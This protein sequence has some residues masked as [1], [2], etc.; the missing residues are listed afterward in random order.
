MKQVII[1]RILSDVTLSR[2]LSA[3]GQLQL[4]LRRRSLATAFLHISH[5]Q[6]KS[7]NQILEGL[8]QSNGWLVL[9]AST[10]RH[11]NHVHK[12]QGT[13]HQHINWPTQHHTCLLIR[14]T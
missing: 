11:M 13:N 4:L 10:L 7:L 3:L 2:Q 5:P 9:I 6:N 14:W 8:S 12:I 1:F